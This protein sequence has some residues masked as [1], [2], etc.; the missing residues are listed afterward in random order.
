MTAADYL[1]VECKTERGKI[2]FRVPAD[3]EGYD[4]AKRVIGSSIFPPKILTERDD[5]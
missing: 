1:E 2:K 5:P 3:K 4:F